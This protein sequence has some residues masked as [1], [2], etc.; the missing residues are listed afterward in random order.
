M[1]EG[2]YYMLTEVYGQQCYLAVGAGMNDIYEIHDSCQRL[3]K[4]MENRFFADNNG[5]Y[6]EDDDEFVERDESERAE[7]INKLLMYIRKRDI[8][9]VRR[10]YGHLK[11]MMFQNK[12]DSE[13]FV[14]FV[15]QRLRL[16]WTMQLME[17][18]M[19]RGR[20]RSRGF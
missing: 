10:E 7:C 9:L 3:L 16:S 8:E 17:V 14:K 12:S 20:N 1:A 11:H 6:Y 4:L 5:I 2:I 13:T 18:S 15:L 19:D